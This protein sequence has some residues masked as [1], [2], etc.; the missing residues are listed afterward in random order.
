MTGT[1]GQ[2]SMTKIIELSEADLLL[3][4]FFFDENVKYLPIYL[5]NVYVYYH[6]FMLS[7]LV[8][9]KILFFIVDNGKIHNE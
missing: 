4:F 6:Y 5:L 9:E 1:T 8:V 7:I 2:Y 3:V